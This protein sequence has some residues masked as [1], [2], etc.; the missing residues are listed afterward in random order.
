MLES[1]RLP[2]K[3]LRRDKNALRRLATVQRVAMS[4]VVRRLTR[5]AA[6]GRGLFP[7]HDRKHADANRW[8][9]CDAQ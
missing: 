7:T 1:K 9:V 8:E 3:M 6:R 4:I 5:K 2:S